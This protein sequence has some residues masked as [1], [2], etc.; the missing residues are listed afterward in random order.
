[1]ALLAITSQPPGQNRFALEV[2]ETERKRATLDGDKRLWIILDEHNTDR[3]HQS[4]YLA[5]DSK[6]GTFSDRF[7]KQIQSAF[8]TALRKRKS[9]EVKRWDELS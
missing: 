6:F 8:L 3:S 9:F 4:Y 7:R 5:P 2:P 1:M